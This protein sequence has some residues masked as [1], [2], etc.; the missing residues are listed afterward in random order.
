MKKIKIPLLILGFFSLLIPL[1]I[2]ARYALSLRN[3]NQAAP[4]PTEIYI[5]AIPLIFGIAFIYIGIR[6][7]K[8][9]RESP[10]IPIITLRAWIICNI[11]IGIIS[12]ILGGGIN[13][14]G[15]LIIAA[16]Y[17]YFARALNTLKNKT[18]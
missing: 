10:K 11:A 6:L 14:I 17:W 8:L 4:N 12:I 5:G 13:I 15:L 2:A 18:A 1:G 16:I 9:L 3:E 7:E